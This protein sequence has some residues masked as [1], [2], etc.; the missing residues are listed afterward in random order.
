MA[1][2]NVLVF[3]P[4]LREVLAK[5]E[6]KKRGRLTE[7][8]VLELRDRAVCMPLKPE[9]ADVLAVEHGAD[10]DAENVWPEYAAT[11]SEV[12]PR[13]VL[14]VLGSWAS[15]EALEA[16]AE[17]FDFELDLEFSE[18]APDA[19]MTTAFE[20]SFDRVSPSVKEEDRLAIA[21][22]TAVAYLLS[23]SIT[24][25]NAKEVSTRALGLISELFE[26]GALAVKSESAGIAHGRA[27]WLE[28]GAFVR[29]G[30]AGALY[31]A[32]VRRP[33]AGD[34]AYYSCGLHLLGEP[35]VEI[36][37]EE[38]PLEALSWLDALGGYLVVEKR[39]RGVHHGHTF[40]RRSEDSKRTL[41]ARPCT[42]YDGED[43]FFNPWGYLRIT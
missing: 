33:L 42:N 40:A 32:W 10:F 23:G 9:D 16:L 37:N 8:E 14:C 4:P 21:S 35:D 41:Q 13:H 3:I 27:R 18:L 19:R 26:H 5:A 31:S 11:D 1:N 25:Q 29:D 20:V 7:R 36:S 17:R 43:F 15:F 39:P 28:L 38:S 2:E 24:L 6:Q 12:S 30:D 22:H 34:D